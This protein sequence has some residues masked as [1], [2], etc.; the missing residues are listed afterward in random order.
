M[1]FYGK[2]ISGR[3]IGRK[4]G[5]PTLNFAVAEN[6]KI[7]PGVFA[8]RLFL[9]EKSWPAILFFGK[10]KTFDNQE[11]LEIHVLNEFAENPSEA[12]FEIL[13][14]IREAA[15]F[16]STEKLV[17]QIEKD[18]ARAREILGVR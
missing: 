12:E 17:A 8:A 7:E 11:T 3:G 9:G 4:L 1:R 18:C 10:R 5:F 14:K 15:K 16:D 13:G 2:I 6:W